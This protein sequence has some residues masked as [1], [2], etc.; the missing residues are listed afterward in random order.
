[1][2][3]RILCLLLVMMFAI[4]ALIAEENKPKIAVVAFSINDARNTKL[5]N[6]ASAVRNQVQANIVKTG[7]YLL[8]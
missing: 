2:K 4:S 7:Q 3:K 1:M 8:V 5:V 6:D